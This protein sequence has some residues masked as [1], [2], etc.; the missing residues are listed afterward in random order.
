[1]DLTVAVAAG[2]EV[3]RRGL[4]AMLGALS[5][6]SW[7]SYRTVEEIVVGAIGTGWAQLSLVDASELRRLRPDAREALGRT[8]IVAMVPSLEPSVLAV[9]VQCAADGYVVLP[10]LSTDSLGR[11]LHEVA[12]GGRHL[13][14]EISSFLLTWVQAGAS[15][16]AGRAQLLSTRER[17]VLDLLVAGLSNKEISR[18]LGISL[19]GAKRHVSSILNKL[20]SPSRSHVVSTVLR[21]EAAWDQ[22]VP[23]LR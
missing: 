14:D 3:V 12:S 5:G 18:E 19:H 2:P 15:D 4:E 10:E 11:A 20:D 13:P 7:R 8:R 16:V 9:A 17:E 1:M 22:P 6:V 21:S 23:S